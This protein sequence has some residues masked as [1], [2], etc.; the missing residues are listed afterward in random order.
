MTLI[1]WITMQVKLFCVEMEQKW[2]LRYLLLINALVLPYI[3]VEIWYCYLF[4][5]WSLYFG[6]HQTFNYSTNW[7][8][9]ITKYK[10]K[11]EKKKSI[12]NTRKSFRLM[13]IT[14]IRV[15][16]GRE[17]WGH[18]NLFEVIVDNRPSLLTILQKST[19]PRISI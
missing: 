16:M 9:V 11:Y 7:K 19:V 15:T 2:N 13:N 14:V 3:S 18:V 4:I 5:C 12:I 17:G 1:I 10:S 8:Y 6:K